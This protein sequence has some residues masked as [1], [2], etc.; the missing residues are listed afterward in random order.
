[1]DK[2]HRHVW[3]AALAGLGLRLLFVLRFPMQEAGDTPI[4]E[5]LARNWLHHHVYGLFLGQQLTPVD[6]RGPGYPAFLASLYALFGTSRLP[7]RLAQAALDL[8]T[9]FVIAA[10]AARLAPLAQRQRVAVA[11]LWLAATCPFVAN[12]AAA[13]LS[14]VLATFL[15]ALALLVFLLPGRAAEASAGASLNPWWYGG[16]IVGCG[17][18]VRPEAP[19]LLVSVALVL[20]ARWRRPADWP[21]LLRAGALAGAGLLLPLAPWAARNWRT[22]HHVQFLAPRYTEMPGEYVPRGFYAWTNTWLVRF[23]DVYLAPWKLGD[24]PIRVEDLPASAFDSAEERVRVAALLDRYNR[25]L[26]ISEEVDRGFAQIARERTARQ[27]LRTYLWVPLGRV[28]TL[29]FTPRVELLPLSGHLW[30]PGRQWNEDPADFSVTLGLGL[31][32]FLYV[33]LALAGAWRWRS[34]PGVALLATFIIVRTA[35]LTQVDTPEP[36]YVVE[37]FPAVLSLGA[38]AWAKPSRGMPS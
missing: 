20:A 2:M 18:L 26:T 5:E 29:W 24:E 12:Y 23:R 7:V 3:L 16:L 10:L 21:R 17:A 25:E 4:Y 34:Q 15:T 13:R 22:L 33:G 14:E 38:L 27:P 37:C 28:A 36:R 1:M 19:L 32:N 6:I 11:G 31:L 35:F 30:P 8:V 9:C